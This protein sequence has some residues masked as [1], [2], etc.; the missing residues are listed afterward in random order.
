MNILCLDQ[1]GELGGAQRCLLDLIPAMADRGWSVHVAAPG[2]GQLAE[3]A[4]AM[5]ATVDPIRCGPYSSGKKTLADM[6][7]FLGEAPRL[8]G[9]IRGLVWRYDADLIYVNGPRPLPAVALAP[10]KVPRVLCHSHSLRD[11]R[12]RRLAGRSLAMVRAAVVA[13][14][15]FVATPLLPYCGDRGIRVVY[16]GVRHMSLPSRAAAAA[17]L[18]IGAIGRISPERGKRISCTRPAFCTA[19]R[20]NAG[21][22][23]AA[24]RYFPTQRPC[25]TARHWRRWPRD[26][27][28]NS[29]AGRRMWR[30][31]WP[32]W[33]FW[34]FRPRQSMR[35]RA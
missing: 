25:D 28:W 24:R 23:S 16:N 17:E 22:S 11:G 1:F 9:E 8:A 7:R 27:P 10:R 15:R 19:R 6:A 20:P 21:F 3:R 5:Q 35:R 34:W 2:N 33:T 26:C 32:R 30:A 4:A 31:C 29:P 18:R 13:S 12:A 14:C